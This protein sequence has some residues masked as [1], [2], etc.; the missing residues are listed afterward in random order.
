MRFLYLMRE[1]LG[2]RESYF[3]KQKRESLKIE[4]EGEK[5]RNEREK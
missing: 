3:K 1:R 2:E 4:R 5:G